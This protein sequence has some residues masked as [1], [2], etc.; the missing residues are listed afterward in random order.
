MD[1]TKEISDYEHEQVK[2]WLVTAEPSRNGFFA[3]MS[4]ELEIL[5][6]KFR[7]GQTYG[8]D[9]LRDVVE[10]VLGTPR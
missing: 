3:V 2:P 9:D 6:D 8:Y 4:G 7:S 10:D 1:V 5:I